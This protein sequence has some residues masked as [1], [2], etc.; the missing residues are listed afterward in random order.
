MV[1]IV[2]L[3]LDNSIDARER[4]FAKIILHRSYAKVRSAF[5]GCAPFGKCIGVAKCWMSVC[6]DYCTKRVIITPD[7]PAVVFQQIRRLRDT[8]RQTIG[9]ALVEFAFEPEAMPRKG[10]AGVAELLEIYSSLVQGFKFPVKREHVLFIRRCI[11]PLFKAPYLYFS[12]YHSSL[13]DCA[14]HIVDK[15]PALAEL[16]LDYMFKHWYV[17]GHGGSWCESQLDLLHCPTK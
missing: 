10:P 9:F 8:I 17:V 14:K 12:W 7:L 6:C 2:Y 13:K 16:L 15:Q 1:K 5:C 4:R 11:L 3:I